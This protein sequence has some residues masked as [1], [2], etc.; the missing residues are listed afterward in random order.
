MFAIFRT[1]G[2]LTQD[3][4]FDCD[5][6]EYYTSKKIAENIASELTEIWNEKD[7]VGHP[8]YD[9]KFHVENVSE[10]YIRRKNEV[11]ALRMAHAEMAV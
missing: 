6:F 1:K 2:N 8:G 7:A 10:E 4:S 5:A 9:S 11:W 3:I